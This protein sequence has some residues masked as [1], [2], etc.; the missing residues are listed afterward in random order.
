MTA[1]RSAA[2]P[3]SAADRK[4]RLRDIVARESPAI[5]DFNLE[6]GR[7]PERDQG[8]VKVAVDVCR[9]RSLNCP[10]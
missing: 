3:A 5:G 6:E 4:R 7:Q 10:G 8:R 1:S 2:A 9:G